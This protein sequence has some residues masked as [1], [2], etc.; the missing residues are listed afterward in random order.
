MLTRSARPAVGRHTWEPEPQRLASF[1]FD[2]HAENTIVAWQ[3]V[4][5]D[6]DEWSELRFLW[7]SGKDP[8]SMRKPVGRL[9]RIQQPLFDMVNTI[10]E[11]FHCKQDI[12]PTDWLGRLAANISA[13][14]EEPAPTAEVGGR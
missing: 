2:W 7:G 9:D 12:D 4:E 14:G 10:D 1:K 8:V 3:G 6:F 11:D 5:H 13:G